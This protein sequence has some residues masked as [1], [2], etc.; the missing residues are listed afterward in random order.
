MI[1]ILIILLGHLVFRSVFQK[2]MSRER[3]GWEEEDCLV[4]LF[5]LMTEGS[6]HGREEIF[7]AM[8][9]QFSYFSG[10]CCVSL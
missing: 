1:R 5:V 2:D 7:P 6:V 9:V 10:F 4:L 8:P 3:K